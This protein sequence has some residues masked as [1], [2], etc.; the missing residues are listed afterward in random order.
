MKDASRFIVAGAATAAVLSASIWLLKNR[1]RQSALSTFRSS[2]TVGDRPVYVVRTCEQ[3][4][5]LVR[6]YNLLKETVI[7]F[8]AEW[9]RNTPLSIVQLSFESVNIIIQ[10]EQMD[11]LPPPSLNAM[12]KDENI[13]KSGVGIR[14]DIRKLLKYMVVDEVNG[15]V[16][17]TDAAHLM[18]HK[19]LRTSLQ[20]M[21][22][23]YLHVTLNKDPAIRCGNWDAKELSDAQIHYAACDSY[24]SRAVFLY[25]YR[26]Y[27]ASEKTPLSVLEWSL[28]NEIET[29]VND[30]ETNNKAFVLVKDENGEH[31]SN[32]PLSSIN[33]VKIGGYTKRKRPVY[34]DC[35]LLSPDGQ[36]LCRINKRKLDWYVHRGLGI[37]VQEEPY[38]VQ[39]KFEPKSRTPS[40]SI[41]LE[42]T[43]NI[44]VVCGKNTDYVCHSIL[45]HK[46]RRFLPEKW[47]SHNNHDNVVLC[48]PCSVRCNKFDDIFS[49]QILKKFGF[50]HNSM[51]IIINKEVIAARKT[52]G[53][54]I[55]I[56]E[57]S[58]H[59]P[60]AR[61]LELERQL[62]RFLQ[63]Y[64]CEL[65]QKN[66]ESSAKK[67]ENCSYEILSEEDF[68]KRDAYASSD[69]DSS[70][71]CDVDANPEEAVPPN[72]YKTMQLDET[73]GVHNFDMSILIKVNNLN[74]YSVDPTY[75]SPEEHVMR[76]ILASENPSKAAS[77]FMILWRKHF[78][79]TMHPR[80]MKPG[81]NVNEMYK[82]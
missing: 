70:P 78:L 76:N 73:E 9:T 4:E 3:F 46:Y 29:S 77:E 39:L 47:K 44:C 56:Y 72:P 65:W 7:G 33:G 54:L 6:Q 28:V 74:A 50:A 71:L 53:I 52:A 30:A 16:D 13:L 45:P 62:L 15:V 43:D 11:V 25:F 42:A 26:L 63:K 12:M 48:I 22:E 27:A 24:Y 61:K 38:T 66:E 40:N 81:W 68:Q 59:P 18:G 41:R 19:D 57:G 2:Q 35:R 1:K 58:I 32:V 17:I 23:K 31:Y 5:S 21:T 14:D 64:N 20:Y 8:D 55:R 37:V 75:V 36:L 51:P 60:N 49:H 34:E 69:S 10:V 79:E 67:S 82:E 80:F